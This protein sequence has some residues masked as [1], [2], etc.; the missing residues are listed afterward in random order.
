MSGFDLPSL[1]G[2]DP[3]QLQQLAREFGSQG[4]QG[5]QGPETPALLETGRMGQRALD[6]T[7]STSSVVFAV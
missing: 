6:G 7:R 1:S 4:R 2:F 5:P 3:Q